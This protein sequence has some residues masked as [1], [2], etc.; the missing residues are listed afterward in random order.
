MSPSPFSPSPAGRDGA[1]GQKFYK[2]VLAL[3]RRLARY[4]G[5]DLV[6]NPYREDARIARE[7][8]ALHRIIARAVIARHT[9]SEWVLTAGPTHYTISP[10]TPCPSDAALLAAK[11]CVV[12]D[13][14]NYALV[15]P[16]L[17]GR[18]GKSTTRELPRR[19]GEIIAMP[20]H[21]QRGVILADA[22]PYEFNAFEAKTAGLRLGQRV[23]FIPRLIGG[24]EIASDVR[25]AS[26][27]GIRRAA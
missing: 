2:G 5:P 14:T 1:A 22:R 12:F 7:L 19:S 9:I 16:Y 13:W 26:A 4:A 25:P 17:R 15:E 18:Y 10:S 6:G 11:Y 20:Y 3:E 8:G 24:T 23:T 27:P 21:R